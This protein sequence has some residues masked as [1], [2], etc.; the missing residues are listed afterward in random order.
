MFNTQTKTFKRIIEGMLIPSLINDTEGRV[1]FG[2]SNEGL[3]EFDINTYKI[4]SHTKEARGECHEDVYF[5]RNI[6]TDTYGNIWVVAWAALVKYNIKEQ[7][8]YKVRQNS[9]DPHSLPDGQI[10][11][12]Y[13]DSKN[14]IWVGHTKGIGLYNMKDDYIMNFGQSLGL[15]GS[16]VNAIVED[17]SCNLWLS[18]DKGISKFCLPAKVLN[19]DKNSAYIDSLPDNYVYF[20]NYSKD[21]GINNERFMNGKLRASTGDIYFGGTKGI[22]VF[23]PNKI[24]PDTVIRITSYNVCYTKLLRSGTRLSPSASP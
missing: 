1:W 22:N 24:N 4:K 15:K 14:R 7:C 13:Q 17:D 2:A 21:D 9:S 10:Y 20:Y 18:T 23:N 6:S 3:I 5:L 12:C 8:F 19:I 11:C 16:K